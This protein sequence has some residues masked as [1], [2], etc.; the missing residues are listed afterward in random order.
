M[1]KM[2]FVLLS[3]MFV[4]AM[5]FAL[6]DDLFISEYMEGSSNNKSFEIFNGTGAPVDLSD[7]QIIRANNGAVW[8]DG[9][10]FTYP[11]TIIADGDVWVNVNGSETLGMTA[12]A[13]TVGDGLTWFNG[14]D[15]IGLFNGSTFRIFYINNY[16]IGFIIG[17]KF[18]FGTL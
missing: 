16:L 8:A 13:D 17:K 1:K 11:G 3:L 18:N 12:V 15:S 9:T 4:T 10:L 14:D 7:Y 2:I 6:A 5:L